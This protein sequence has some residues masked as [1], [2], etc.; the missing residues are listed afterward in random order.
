ML[1]QM[2]PSPQLRMAHNPGMAAGPSPQLRMAPNPQLAVMPTPS[3]GISPQPQQQP[4]QHV[5]YMQQ[6]QMQSVGSPQPQV[7]GGS[8]QPQ[9][10]VQ[11][12][13]LQ[14][15]RI[16][17]IQR[18]QMMPMQHAQ[19]VEAGPIR[20]EPMHMPKSPRNSSPQPMRHASPQPMNPPLIVQNVQGSRFREVG[21][22]ETDIKPV[23]QQPHW[24]RQGRSVFQT[25]PARGASRR[26]V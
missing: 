7:M 20:W 1:C 3:L 10:P 5:Q 22:V 13:A 26:P 6:L 18:P 23:G 24:A 9:Q 15:A 4:Q 19:Y 25:Q 16:Q 2:Q 17:Q 11:Y 12:V 8:P 14:Q 21:I